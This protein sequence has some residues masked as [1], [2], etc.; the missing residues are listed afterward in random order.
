[1][2]DKDLLISFL[3]NNILTIVYK[4]LNGDIQ[5]TK[6]TL[7]DSLVPNK[8]YYDDPYDAT[9]NDDIICVW[10]VNL[11]EW[12][13]FHFANVKSVGLELYNNEN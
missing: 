9:D 7:I 12:K 8:N 3:E 2:F 10:D 1:M 6:C 5:S 4:K 11:N 13:V